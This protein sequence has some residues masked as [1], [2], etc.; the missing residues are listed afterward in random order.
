M[1]DPLQPDGRFN[2]LMYV[3]SGRTFQ[4][5]HNSCYQAWKH[6][7]YYMVRLFQVHSQVSADEHFAEEVVGAILRD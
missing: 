3:R 4:K 7:H 6:L 2:G 5:L 1:P